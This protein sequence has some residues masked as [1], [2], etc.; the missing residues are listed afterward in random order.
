[1]SLLLSVASVMAADLNVDNTHPACDDAVETPFCT[2]SAALEQAQPGDTI[3]VADST[4]FEAIRIDKDNLT[5]RGVDHPIIDGHGVLFPGVSIDASEVSFE[6]FEIVHG[7]IGISIGGSQ[8]KVKRNWV[9]DTFTGIQVGVGFVSSET[10]HVVTRNR[11]YNITGNE[12]E[13]MGSKNTIRR[14]L[15]R[16]N[17]QV[18]IIV[19]LSSSDNILINNR[20]NKNPFGGFAIGGSRN[21]II[22]RVLP[23]YS[24]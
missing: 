19:V 8:N 21:K 13:V 2:I 4:Y 20:A 18:G 23:I 17:F 12:I 7:M 1:M 14:N 9:H 6:G 10:F 16:K 3:T 11:V 24:V 5:V 22:T 15:S